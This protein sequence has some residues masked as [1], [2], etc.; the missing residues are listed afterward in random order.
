MVT[1]DILQDNVALVAVLLLGR[2]LRRVDDLCHLSR[3][4]LRLGAL[5]LASLRG[6]RVE[7]R[8]LLQCAGISNKKRAPPRNAVLLFSRRRKPVP[9]GANSSHSLAGEA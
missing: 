6:W 2:P 8:V 1:L 3:D 9:S 4:A 7:N 5:M